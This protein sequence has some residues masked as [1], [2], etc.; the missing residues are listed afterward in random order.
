MSGQSLD[1]PI[2]CPRERTKQKYDQGL[3]KTKPD[4]TWLRATLVWATC[5]I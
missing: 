1:W 2:C 3:V 5:Y 4:Q